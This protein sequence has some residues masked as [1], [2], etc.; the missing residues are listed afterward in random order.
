M[1]DAPL[2]AT[3]RPAGD[4]TRT[5]APGAPGQGFMKALGDAINNLAV[6]RVTVVVGTVTATG[7][8]DL[9]Q[10]TKIELTG[11]GQ[12]VASTSI[13]MALGDSSVIL[14]PKFVEDA[15]YQK[16]HAEAVDQALKVRQQTVD[17]L[18]KGYAAFKD[19]L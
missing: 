18:Q 12:E 1:A 17:L 10:V 13:N 7:A 16:L 15:N 3:N 11:Q 19:L 6:L 4:T 8:D 2:P 5:S 9:H 14:S